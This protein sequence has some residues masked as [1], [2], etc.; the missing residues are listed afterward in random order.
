M[1]REIRVTDEEERIERMY[2]YFA[3]INN[4]PIVYHWKYYM[5][6]IGPEEAISIDMARAAR[7]MRGIFIRLP[8]KLFG[9]ELYIYPSRLK[10]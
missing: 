6:E 5:S 9:T 8:P 4:S 7:A 2:K 1:L 3:E 10:P